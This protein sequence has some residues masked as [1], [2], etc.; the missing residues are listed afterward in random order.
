[1][2]AGRPTGVG[3]RGPVMK[4]AA[5]TAAQAN[6]AAQI[7]LKGVDD[8]GAPSVVHEYF[9]GVG[10]PM[11]QAPSSANRSPNASGSRRF[12]GVGEPG[13][14]VA[15]V[16]ID[17]EAFDGLLKLE[18]ISLAFCVRCPGGWCE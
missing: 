10:S 8:C 2:S 17:R 9:E 11:S 14:E 12:Y 1:M 16:S 4:A 7:Q 3:R 5:S 6:A 13:R 15:D 18:F